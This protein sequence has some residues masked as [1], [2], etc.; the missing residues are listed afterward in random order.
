MIR[1]PGLPEGWDSSWPE[2]GRTS[3][4]AYFTASDRILVAL[5]EPDTRDTAELAMENIDYQAR[6][7]LERDVRGIVVILGD[8]LIDQTRDARQVY[9]VKPTNDWALGFGIVGS[10]M[11]TRAMFALYCGLL[12]RSSDRPTRMFATLG[13]ALKWAELQVANDVRSAANSA[14]HHR[15]QTD[16]NNEV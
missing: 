11:L 5:P 12:Q 15:T 13:G 10:S 2:V 9:A 3:R 8:R 16:R 6:Y 7:F 1:E 4:V 14:P